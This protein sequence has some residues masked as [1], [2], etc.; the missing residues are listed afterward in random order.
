MKKITLAAKIGAFLTTAIA[1][2]AA[3][4]A[5]ERS[6]F[7]LEEVVVTAQK[8]AENSQDVPLSI[9]AF[10]AEGLE[11]L[12]ASQ[13]NDLSASAPSFNI[14]GIEGSQGQMGIRGVVDFGRNVG[15]DA[16]TGIYID[17]VYQGR[18]F[19]ANQPLLGLESVEILRGPQGTL[20]G[21]NTVSGAINLNTKKPGGEFE[22]EVR[23]NVSNYDLIG[24]ALYLSGPL[25]EKMSGS[26]SVAHEEREGYY[27]NK[28]L[29]QDVGAVERD[30]L[31]AKLL[32]QASDELELI[33]AADFGRTESEGPLT[34]SKA[35]PL[36]VTTKDI[37][38][39]DDI[40]YAGGS[41]TVN[42]DLGDEYTLTSIT[43][44]RQSEYISSFDGDYNVGVAEHAFFDEDTDMVSQEVRLVSPKGDAFDWV[45]GLYYY[46]GSASTERSTILF[47]APYNANING[48]FGAPVVAD[49]GIVIQL[50]SSVDT[51]SYAMYVHGNYRFSNSVELTLGLRYTSEDKDLDYAQINN[52]DLVTGI[53]FN[54]T[55]GAL[56]SSSSDDD[57]SPSIGLNWSVADD[58]ML[59]ARYAK[60]YKSGGWN[61]DF[62]LG[63]STAFN[64]DFMQ[65]DQESVDTYEIG[66]KSTWL[67]GKLQANA[68]AFR[69]EFTDFHVQDFS[70]LQYT[71]AA[72]AVTQGGELELTA[73]P[74]D[75]LKLSLNATYLDTFFEKYALGN[76]DLSGADMPYA[77]QWKTY[78]G[79]QYILPLGNSG[80]L[81]FNVDYNF[82]DE[83][84]ADPRTR[85]DDMIASYGT[86]NARVTFNP[87][88]DQW[89][90]AAFVKNGGDKEYYRQAGTT[91]VLGIPRGVLGAPKTYGLS[92]AY[93]LG[94]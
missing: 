65:Y 26:I 33:V 42:Y 2:S 30:N 77:P 27:Y 70:T 58:A 79:A 59:F 4:I 16:R 60:A 71:N 36:F 48:L 15:I 88:N 1:S 14:G 35:N 57:V 67:D 34:T 17:G 80:E 62:N 37:I 41:L 51:K 13:L 7:T 92:F 83:Q 45:A 19:S 25:S 44:Y 32:I 24:S 78:L 55:S 9:Q 56:N 20:F 12:G 81:T 22:G 11:K 72:E 87:N 38:E 74:I 47:G 68:T 82:S 6:G 91:F 75:T 85:P 52:N 53:L 84:S 3:T 8:R 76:L 46:D 40:E 29:D 39:E 50:P 89:Q 66:L 63:G 18:S 10:S 93:Y 90:L 61:A 28:T 69:S 23:A 64:D 54:S 31:R 43:A 21:K 94:R 73:I 86:W 49:E 5:E